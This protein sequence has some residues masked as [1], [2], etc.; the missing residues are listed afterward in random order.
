MARRTPKQLW[1]D[2]VEGNTAYS[3]GGPS[4]MTS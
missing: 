1:R 2:T 3:S 4:A